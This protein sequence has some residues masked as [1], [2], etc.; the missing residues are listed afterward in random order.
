M[1]KVSINK[2]VYKVAEYYN[3]PAI[4]LTGKRSNRL[5]LKARAVAC[6]ILYEK[7]YYTF[8]E[9][10]KALQITK[11]TAI[12]ARN[13]ASFWFKKPFLNKKNIDDINSIESSL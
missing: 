2:V 6:Y 5:V 9:I 3:I 7:Y 10:A 1:N 8:I 13:R 4:E 11:S 12:T